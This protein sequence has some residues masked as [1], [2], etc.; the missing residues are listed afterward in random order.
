MDQKYTGL[1]ILLVDD[2]TELHKIMKVLLNA[3][4]HSMLSAYSGTETLEIL[5]TEKVDV[6][7]LDVT[8]PTMD[9]L[10]VLREI[11]TTTDIPVLMLTAISME[12]TIQNAFLLGADDYL[13]KP[14]SPK[15]VLERI[16]KLFFHVSD[17]PGGM[18]EE[19]NT[20]S[21][22][23]SPSNRKCEVN[24]RPVELSE[25]EVRLF[26]HLMRNPDVTCSYASLIQAGW[27]RGDKTTLQDVEML[28]MAINRLRSKI[29]TN[30]DQPEYIP[31]MTSEGYIFRS[32]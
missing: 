32:D 5:K 24:G 15:Q 16:N 11:R 9:G 14:F 8:M 26:L 2:D 30:L 1:N 12:N 6:V 4:G 20:K 28:Q 23:F 18:N 17:L 25:V 19:L 31:L 21:I 22:K 27:G 7:I 10:E 3:A 29:E 13:I